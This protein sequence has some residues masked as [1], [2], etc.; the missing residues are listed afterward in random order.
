M[1]MWGDMIFKGLLAVYPEGKRFDGIFTV[2][3]KITL[4]LYTWSS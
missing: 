1:Y 2:T 3:V 4:Y